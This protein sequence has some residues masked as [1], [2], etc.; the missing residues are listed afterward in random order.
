MSQAISITNCLIG[1]SKI[2]FADGT[3]GNSDATLRQLLSNID[4][5]I[6]IT[7][8]N[9]IG[10]QT[11]LE[12]LNQLIQKKTKFTPTT[13]CSIHVLFH[14]CDLVPKCHQQTCFDLYKLRILQYLTNNNNNSGF[15]NS[16]INFHLTSI[17]DESLYKV[18]SILVKP[19]QS[20]LRDQFKMYEL[21]VQENKNANNQNQLIK[22]SLFD[23][24]SM[25]HLITFSTEI[26]TDIDGITNSHLCKII[27]NFYSQ[28]NCNLIGWKNE[29]FYYSVVPVGNWIRYLQVENTTE[30][31]AIAQTL[32]QLE[33]QAKE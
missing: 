33:E 30:G 11:E 27:K 8:L 15:D 3:T 9:S 12:I 1:S 22:I 10:N 20:Y 23:K 17:W 7:N 25:I 28:L 4:C 32:L 16:R 26:I 18:C 24:R 2:L 6:W 5:I 19:I 13:I 21:L 29:K 31:R 14:K